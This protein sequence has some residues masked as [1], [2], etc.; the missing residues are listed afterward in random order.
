MRRSTTRF[1]AS[2]SCCQ[3]SVR[4]CRCSSHLLTSLPISS[5]RSRFIGTLFSWSRN[6]ACCSRS[7]AAMECS[8]SSREGGLVARLILIRAQE[9]SNRSMALSGRNRPEI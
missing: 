1:A 9:V 7:R 4:V 5:R 3:R 6:I 8:R 2:R